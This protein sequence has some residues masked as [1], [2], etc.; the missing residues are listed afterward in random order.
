[1]SHIIKRH[2]SNSDSSI[3]FLDIESTS[4]FECIPLLEE[5]DIEPGQDLDRCSDLP[6][7]KNGIWSCA[8]G[9]C[10]LR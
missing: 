10:N 7:I 6:N 1:M 3:S 4:G 8:H 9:T 5:P 2:S